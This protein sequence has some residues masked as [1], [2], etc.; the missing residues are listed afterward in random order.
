MKRPLSPMNFTCIDMVVPS[1]S[2]RRAHVSLFPWARNFTLIAP[3]FG[4]HIKPLIPCAN[5]PSWGAAYSV[6]LVSYGTCPCLLGCSFA[7]L[8]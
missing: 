4:S 6:Y 2:P 1:S 5:V 3:W 7:N 8:G